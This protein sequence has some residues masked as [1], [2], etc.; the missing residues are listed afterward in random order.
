VEWLTGNLYLV[1]DPNFVATNSLVYIG[2]KEVTVVG[3]TWTPDTAKQLA[4]VIRQITSLPV[5]RVIITSPDPEWA[6]GSAYWKGIGAEL[7]TSRHTC[8]ALTRTWDATVKDTQSR[9]PTYPT[10]LPLVVPSRCGPDRFSLE[11]GKIEVLYLGP[12]HTAADIF[13]YFPEVLVLDAG[14]ILKLFLGN[15]TKANVSAYPETLRNLKEL[16]LPT[17]MIIAGHWTPVHGPDLIDRYLVMLAKLP[18]SDNV[19]DAR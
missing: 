13:V 17:R 16:R 8:E 2:E 3:A 19:P 5:A 9:R 6:G 18:K 14:S 11:D 4:S 1:Q 15:L 7:V 12:S 10:T